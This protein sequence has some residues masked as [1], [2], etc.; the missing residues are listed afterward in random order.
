MKDILTKLQQDYVNYPDNQFIAPSILERFG[1]LH[2][3]DIKYVASLS[4]EELQS[5]ITIAIYYEQFAFLEKMQ[6]NKLIP[7]TKK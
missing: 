3:L 7:S 6:D 4:S 2:K 1:E 5:L